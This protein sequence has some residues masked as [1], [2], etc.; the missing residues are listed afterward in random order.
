MSAT[1]FV[2]HASAELATLTNT[3]SVS[4]TATDPTTISLTVTTPSGTST[5]YTYAASQITKTTTGV[6]T[7]DIACTEPGEWLAVWVGTGTA[8]DVQVVR[9]TVFDADAALY[10]SPEAVKSRLGDTETVDDQEYRSACGA[11]TAWIDR[12]C[13]DYF[14]RRTATL[15]FPACGSYELEI[16]SLVSVTT[17]KT[18][19]AGDGTYETTWTTSDY[20]LLTGSDYNASLGRE[21]R[22][23]TKILAVGSYTFPYTSSY[24]IRRDNVQIAGVWGWPSIPDPVREAALI[25]A[26]DCFKLKDAPFGVAGFGAE[27]FTV[28]VKQNPQALALLQPYRRYPVMVG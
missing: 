25:L 4:G 28:R 2:D 7:K 27:G 26:V 16:P 13:Q 15:T 22:P 17:L 21:T 10:A 23:Y 11:V 1:V 9:W 3:F 12:Y 8:S 6:Y 20:Q 5:T 14:A 24:G 19:S 18:D